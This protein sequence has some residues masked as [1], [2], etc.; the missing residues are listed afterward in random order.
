MTVFILP[1]IQDKRRCAPGGWASMILRAYIECPACEAPVIL[2]VG[3]ARERQPFAVAC[4]VCQS[5][6][7]G[8]TIEADDGL[9]R[10]HLPGI[11]KLPPEL[12][13]ADWK[14]VTTYGDLPNNPES[15]EF[16]AFLSAYQTFGD[17]PFQT[18]L[19]HVATVR[20]FGERVDALEHAYGF[21]LREKWDLLDSVMTRHFAEVW[22]DK[23]SALDRHTLIHRLLYMLVLAMD[24]KGMYPAA[25]YETWSRSF[26]KHAEF[27]EC[28]H[29]II[30]QPDFNATRRRVFEQF[31]GLLRN[32]TE[33]MPTLAVTHLRAR[34]KPIPEGWRVP[35]GR[36][37]SLRD[38]YRQNFEVS[39]QMLPLIIRLQNIAEG[40]APDVI[41]T[42]G[43]TGEWEPRALQTKDYVN[44]I[45]QYIKAKAAT[46]E[47]Y[48]NRHRLLRCYWNSAF[49]RDVRNSIAHAEFDYVMHDGIVTYKSRKVPYY[50][51]IEAL[52]KQVTLLAF[53]LDLCKLY[54]IYG[55]RWDA[56]NGKFMG[57]N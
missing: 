23:P 14:V 30:S 34:E 15:G 46:K 9:P 10:F 57:L 53:W 33:W 36:I 20:W 51:F 38:A 29:S 18:Y 11:K 56:Q 25:K 5:T 13:D 19:Q 24:P 27:S 43:I 1:K 55:S 44:N 54:A 16:S 39:C 32:Y 45:N 28:A 22:P 21:Y 52:I 7:R 17:G 49:S 2:R 35:L 41:R 3:V 47:A 48:L 8:E 6:I 26:K 31:I 50:V 40:R 4:P 37:D 42:P 12:P